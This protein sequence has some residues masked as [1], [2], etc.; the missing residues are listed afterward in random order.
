MKIKPF[1]IKPFPP[2]KPFEI[3]PFEIKPFPTP[4]KGK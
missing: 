3:K 2:T 1:E 4:P